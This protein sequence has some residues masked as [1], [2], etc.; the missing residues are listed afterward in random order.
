MKKTLIVTLAL[1]FVLGLAGTAFAN[2]YS[3]V[4]AGHWAYK[5]VNDLQKAGIMEGAGGKFMGNQTLTRY[6]VAAITARAMAKA[7]KADAAQKATIDKLAVEFSKELNDLGVKVAK[8]EKQLG[9]WSFKGDARVRYQQNADLLASDANTTKSTERFQ[10]RL[11]FYAS[12]KLNDNVNVDLR[13][14]QQNTWAQKKNDGTATY[15]NNEL[16]MDIAKFTFKNA[17][18]T[19]DIVFGRDALWLGSAGLLSDSGGIDGVRIQ[20]NTADFKW[21]VGQYAANGTYLAAGAESP[22]TG[23]AGNTRSF[24]FAQG[25]YPVL[26]NTVLTAGYVKGI[27]NDYLMDNYVV[28]AKAT[29][30]DFTLN[31]D[32]TKNNEDKA[33]GDKKG[34]FGSV[35]V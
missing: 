5:A 17:I 22:L 6:E 7:D 24:W 20:D 16:E 12:T 32:Y 29:L 35:L 26:T 25:S 31:G 18:G 13:I 9:T 27:S 21:S 3:D 1:V 4:P 2:P 34:V 33:P 23:K 10:E 30:G 15:A 8:L 19:A 28:G 14:A 11:R